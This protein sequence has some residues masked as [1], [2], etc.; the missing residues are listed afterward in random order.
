MRRAVRAVCHAMWN[1]QHLWTALHRACSDGALKVVT[2]LIEEEHANVN[3]LTAVCSC[4]S[5]CTNN[6]HSLIACRVQE[7]ET[8]L[9]I[10]AN[11]FHMNVVEYLAGREDVLVD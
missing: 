5:N 6:T 8:P 3:A 10:A 9:I 11:Y 1:A 4:I 2:W 7:K